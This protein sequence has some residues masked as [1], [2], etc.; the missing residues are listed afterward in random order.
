MK[1]LDKDSLE[2]IAKSISRFNKDS[3]PLHSDHDTSS[4][5]KRSNIIFSNLVGLGQH[6]NQKKHERKRSQLKQQNPILAQDDYIIPNSTT[7]G[8][9][10]VSG[11]GAGFYTHMH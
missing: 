1:S 6:K 4:P 3:H 9:P 11:L 5:Q 10:C 8:K 2:Q 7:A